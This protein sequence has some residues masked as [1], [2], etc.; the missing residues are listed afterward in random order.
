MG[1]GQGV[2]DHILELSGNHHLN[3]PDFDVL[4]NHQI[5]GLRSRSQS[6]SD[7]KK[8]MTK[9]NVHHEK[10]RRCTGRSSI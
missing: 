6:S 9:E 5:R 4:R 7:E 3:G 10:M 8:N 1:G 2:R